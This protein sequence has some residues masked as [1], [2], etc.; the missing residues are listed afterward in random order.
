MGFFDDLL[1]MGSE[2][3][4][5]AKDK[6]IKDLAG[7]STPLPATVAQPSV[8]PAAVST[9]LSKPL[10]SSMVMLLVGAVAVAAGAIFFVKKAKA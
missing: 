9:A 4:D 10:D 2:Y 3:A 8:I 5:A 6:A 1:D 7:Q